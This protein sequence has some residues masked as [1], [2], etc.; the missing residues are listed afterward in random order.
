MRIVLYTKSILYKLYYIS[1]NIRILLYAESIVCKFHYVNSN[2]QILSS[3]FY[4][5]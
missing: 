4:C 5:I 1:A 3:K 2:A